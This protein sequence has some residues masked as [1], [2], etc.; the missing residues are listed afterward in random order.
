[1]P[2]NVTGFSNIHAPNERVLVKEFRNTV[3]AQAEF[4]EEFA[5]RWR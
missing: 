2:H 5:E 4:F 3:L 1:M